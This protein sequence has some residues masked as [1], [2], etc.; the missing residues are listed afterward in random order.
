MVSKELV[1]PTNMIKTPSTT[2]PF[3]TL[4]ENRSQTHPNPGIE[5]AEGPTV[6][7]LEI[8][9]TSREGSGSHRR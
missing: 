6:A 7:M 8:F 5:P 3:L 2:F 1:W 4:A 9:K